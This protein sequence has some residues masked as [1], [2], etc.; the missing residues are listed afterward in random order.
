MKISDSEAIFEELRNCLKLDFDDCHFGPCKLFRKGDALPANLKLDVEWDWLIVVQIMDDGREDIVKAI[1]RFC[2]ISVDSFVCGDYGVWRYGEARANAV[3]LANVSLK[4]TVFLPNWYGEAVSSVKGTEY[5]TDRLGVRKTMASSEK[6]RRSYLGTYAPRSF[7]E[8]VSFA[9]HVFATHQEILKNFGAEISILDIG[10]GSGA[11]SLGLLWSLK[12]ARLARLR[13]IT[14]WAIDG[15]E[16]SLGLFSDMIRPLQ[17]SWNGVTICLKPVL[18]NQPWKVIDQVTV[19]VIDV[20][21]SSKF[22]Q[23]LDS[24]CDCH[25]VDAAVNAV[26]S[27][28]GISMWISNPGIATEVDLFMSSSK[29]DGV[30]LSSASVEFKVVG[31][32]GHAD[33]IVETV[34]LLAKAALCGSQK[35]KD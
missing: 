23:E 28:S 7:G 17:A 14:V 4:T 18:T 10:S 22:L 32:V 34:S 24:P 6:A 15:N 21:V 31:L 11:A 12:K 2:H 27:P 3:Q 19:G 26:L 9:D 16:K 33:P 35:R 13:K 29:N 30:V 5:K 8:M 20:A 1:S 25:L